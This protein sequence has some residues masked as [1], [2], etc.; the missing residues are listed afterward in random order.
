MELLCKDLQNFIILDI[1]HSYEKEIYELNIIKNIYKYLLITMHN[2]IKG[3]KNINNIYHYYDKQIAKYLLNIPYGYIPDD[4]I[5]LIKH[6]LQIIH[7]D[8]NIMI[9]DMLCALYETKSKNGPANAQHIVNLFN[10]IDKD[11]TYVLKYLV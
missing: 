11:Y 4:K 9:D 8:G 3:R 7:D 5:P 10:M 6:I 1:K 2:S